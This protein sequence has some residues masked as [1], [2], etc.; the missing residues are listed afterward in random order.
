MQQCEQRYESLYQ[1][2][3]ALLDKQ[4]TYPHSF[5]SGE[6]IR[7]LAKTMLKIDLNRTETRLIAMY[8]CAILKAKEKGEK[9]WINYHTN[10]AK[11]YLVKQVFVSALT[12][13][14]NSGL[15]YKSQAEADQFGAK[16][17]ENGCTN[18]VEC[19]ECIDCHNCFES[20]M[21]MQCRY[22]TCCYGLVKASNLD[23]WSPKYPPEI[24]L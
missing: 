11:T 4:N 8:G 16:L 3:E 12:E 9:C 13:K 24:V 23:N 1:V 6:A 20:K 21:L 18:C 19:S 5:S 7:T 22:C 15:S 2:L 17:D 10:L 14:G